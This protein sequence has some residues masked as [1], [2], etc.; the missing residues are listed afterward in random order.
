MAEF[1]APFGKNQLGHADFNAPR[2]GKIFEN[3]VPKT[4][5]SLW[6][7][8][9]RGPQILAEFLHFLAVIP[10]KT[11]GPW[12]AGTPPPGFCVQTDSQGCPWGPQAAV[13]A[14]GG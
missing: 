5:D 10:L 11:E 8:G 9:S 7:L 1:R 12:L 2:E 4:A 14:G 13:P 3:G 6:K